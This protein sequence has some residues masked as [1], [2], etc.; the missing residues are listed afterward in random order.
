[1]SR[2][3]LHIPTFANMQSTLL[4]FIALFSSPALGLS[5]DE[6]DTIEDDLIDYFKNDYTGL[7]QLATGL[8]LCEYL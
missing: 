7:T 2:D 4:L 5:Q 8:R 1:M 6:Y 3:L